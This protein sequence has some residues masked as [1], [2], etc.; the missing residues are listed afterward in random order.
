MNN[1]ILKENRCL[2]LLQNSE[3]KK[4]GCKKLKLNLQP[5]KKENLK[6]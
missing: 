5:K 3:F 6:L 4:V 2:M 1:W